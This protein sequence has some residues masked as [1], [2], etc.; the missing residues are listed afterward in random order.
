MRSDGDLRRAAAPVV[1]NVLLVGIA[2]V[3]A[4]ALSVLAMGFLEGSGTPTGEAAFE[5]EQVPTGLEM[6]AE[7]LGTDVSVELNGRP[8]A[9]FD[10]GEAGRTVLVPTAPNDRITV[11]SRDGDR[12]VLVDKRI[13][14]RSEIG[15]FVAYY[16]FG[17]GSG[18]TLEDQSGN[19]NDGTLEGDPTWLGSGGLRFDGNDDYV[20]VE[21]ISAPVAV[22]EFTVAVAYRQR[23]PGSDAVSQLVEHTW[24]GNEWFLET[25]DD[26]TGDY[27]LEYAVGF[28]DAAGQLQ[29][30]Y[31][32]AHG[33][34]RVAVGTYDGSDFELYV[35][36]ARVDGG[37]YSRSVD[38]GDLTLARDFE[39][40]NQYLEGDVYEVR[41]YYEAVDDSEVDSITRAMS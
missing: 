32:Y 17:A 12:T 13:D 39:S 20:E 40:S 14:E 19:G 24:S 10:A 6:T 27:R 2:I 25:R 30:G 33:E 28:P 22:D 1:G 37:S 31:D 16:T 4:V 7:A 5:Y 23:G 21:D 18:S 29:S 35:D 36:G 38:M 15:D 9:R 41:L 34:R 11:V 8:F 26:G 3:L